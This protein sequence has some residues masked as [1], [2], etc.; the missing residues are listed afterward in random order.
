MSNEYIDHQDHQ[1]LPPYKY[2]AKWAVI[3]AVAGFILTLV[4]YNTGMFDFSQGILNSIIVGFSGIALSITLIILG[5]K[6]YK[7]KVNGGH[8]SL[9]NGLIWSFIYGL[10]ATIVGSLLAMIFYTYL[11]PDFFT[12]M[13]ENTALMLENL[14]L[15]GEA[16]DQQLAELD[17][18]MNLKTQMKNSFV[19]GILVSLITGGITTL[20]IKTK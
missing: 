3:S 18:S 8:L 11:A 19:Y 10:I 6:E 1:E 15:E 4:F 13:K 2:A 14:G 5:L 12:E 17:K 9:N 20:V 16:L 7:N